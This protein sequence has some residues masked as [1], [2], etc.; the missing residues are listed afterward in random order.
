MIREAL[1]KFCWNK[2]KAAEHLG[3]KPQ[4]DFADLVEMM[5]DADLA[6]LEGA[7]RP[8]G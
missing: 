2:T 8:P 1:E 3:W 4:T 5:V 7:P 6:L